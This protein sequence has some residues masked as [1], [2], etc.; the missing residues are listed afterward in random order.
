MMTFSYVKQEKLDLGESPD[1][2]NGA[3][4]KS[5]KD[6]DLEIFG[7]EDGICIS[8]NNRTPFEDA[9]RTT[10]ANGLPCKR[11]GESSSTLASARE[12]AGGTHAKRGRKAAGEEV[13]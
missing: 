3:G 13:Q 6:K 10:H 12:A 1:K 5:G 8:C 7:P 4:K 11:T 9:E 2:P